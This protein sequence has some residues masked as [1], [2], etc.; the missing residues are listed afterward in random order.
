[1]V[2]FVDD[3]LNQNLMNQLKITTN[4]NKDSC[5]NDSNSSD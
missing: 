3:F 2:K 5:V 1:M 4:Q